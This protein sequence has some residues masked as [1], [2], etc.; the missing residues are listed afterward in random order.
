LLLVIFSVVLFLFWDGPLWT[1]KREASH[2]M[3]FLVSYAAVIPAAALLLLVAR[4]FTGSHLV[5]AT[6]STWAIK[7]MFTST[8]YLVIARGTAHIPVAAPLPPSSEAQATAGFEYRPAKGAFAHGALSGAV[9]LKDTPAPG[10]VIL[11]DRPLP[12]A[13]LADATGPLHLWVGGA[14]YSE[15]V[16]LGQVGQD[17]AIENKD[18]SLH[19]LH[20]YERGRTASNVPVPATDKPHPLV[21]PDPGIYEARCD[22]HATERA[23]MVIVDHP[24]VVRAGD[25]GQFTLTDVPV[26]PVTLIVVFRASEKETTSLLRR[27]TARVEASETTVVHIDLSTPEVA[28]ERL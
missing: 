12:G 25:G 19:T 22:T 18:P 26:G 11:I 15:N 14:R 6:A 1:A 4:R 8:V 27:V 13:E 7:L 21:M 9:V 3:R 28:E 20:L 17:L 16:Y 10:A 5:A 24:Y 23:T 2:V